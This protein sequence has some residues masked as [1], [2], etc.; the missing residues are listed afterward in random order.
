MKEA[1]FYVI[2]EPAG[3]QLFERRYISFTHSSLIHST[4]TLNRLAIS[5]NHSSRSFTIHSQHSNTPKYSHNDHSRPTLLPSYLVT[6]LQ[7]PFNPLIQNVL[8]CQSNFTICKRFWQK[9][10]KSSPKYLWKFKYYTV[11]R[12]CNLQSIYYTN[13]QIQWILRERG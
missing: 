4:I 1:P 9:Y 13:Y 5:F 12:K 2:P 10:Q 8:H 6:Y 11:Q 3:Y 7:F